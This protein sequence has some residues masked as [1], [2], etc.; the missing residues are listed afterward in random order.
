VVVAPVL[1][2]WVVPKTQERLWVAPRALWLRSKEEPSARAPG[3]QVQV[4]IHI[5]RRRK[6]KKR[7][8]TTTNSM[9]GTRILE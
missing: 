2:F 8:T 3:E 1:E 7:E 6:K 9:V 4:Q 5:R